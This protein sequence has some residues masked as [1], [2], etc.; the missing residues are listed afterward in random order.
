M[1]SRLLADHG[2]LVRRS[3]PLRGNVRYAGRPT[4]FSQLKNYFR[5]AGLKYHF[6]SER[7]ANPD[8]RPWVDDRQP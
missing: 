1:K 7:N 8:S 4:M 3:P 5:T 2:G 6:L